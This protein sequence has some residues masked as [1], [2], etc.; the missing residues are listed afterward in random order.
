MGVKEKRYVLEN[1]EIEKI[2]QDK[3]T[4]YKFSRLAFS[5]YIDHYTFIRKCLRWVERR[6][7]T[8]TKYYHSWR[9][10]HSEKAERN[11]AKLRTIKNTQ[12][13][14]RT[15]LI[16]LLETLESKEYKMNFEYYSVFFHLEFSFQ[17]KDY[18]TLRT[19]MTDTLLNSRKAII[20]SLDYMCYNETTK[21]L[22]TYF[23]QINMCIDEGIRL[24]KRFTPVTNK[25]IETTFSLP[26]EED[27]TIDN[28]EVIEEEDHH[29]DE[30]FDDNTFDDLMDD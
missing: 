9:G 4:Y 14:L 18:N 11:K 15:K 22:E 21:S 7:R 24:V 1:K 26:I 19:K 12:I 6:M 5:D 10:N 30:Y 8:I 2:I 3:T 16:Q 25:R 23:K 29:F 13:A 27:A 28:N 17:D 20:K